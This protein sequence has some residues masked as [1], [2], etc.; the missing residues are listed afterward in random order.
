M[1]SMSDELTLARVEKHRLWAWP[2]RWR[3]EVGDEARWFATRKA[4]MTWADSRIRLSEF[5]EWR[6]R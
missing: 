2:R 6:Q 3:A 5:T 4:A 1:T